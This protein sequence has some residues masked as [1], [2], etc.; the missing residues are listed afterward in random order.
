MNQE[1]QTRRL[2]SVSLS[3]PSLQKRIR[4]LL[5]DDDSDFSELVAGSLEDVMGI[6]VERAADPFEAMKKME[7]SAFHALIL[8]W[9]LPHLNGAQTLKRTEVSIVLEPEMSKQWEHRQVPV[10][11]IS[12]HSEEM[13]SFQNSPHFRMSGFVSKRQSLAAILQQIREQLTGEGLM[14]QSA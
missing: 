6:S 2:E 9:N 5:I 11:V 1:E 8:D 12:A 10:I 13:F 3:V 7:E 4:V 14:E